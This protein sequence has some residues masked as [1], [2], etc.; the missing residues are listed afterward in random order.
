[1]VARC[2]TKLVKDG[3]NSLDIPWLVWIVRV[4]GDADKAIFRQR[5]SCPRPLAFLREPAMGR[6]MM[7]M[8][9]IAQGKKQID[10]QKISGHGVSF[11]RWLTSSRVTTPAFGWTGNRGNPCFLDTGVRRVNACRAKSETTWPTV[12]PRCLAISLAARRMSSSRSRVVRIASSKEA[13]QN[14]HLMFDD[15][16]SHGEYQEIGQP[17]RVFKQKACLITLIY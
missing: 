16:A 7:D 9:R 13:E 17:G 14:I 4:A 8:H 1:V 10:I 11:R 15:N 5:A 2:L 12:L 3:R 6:F